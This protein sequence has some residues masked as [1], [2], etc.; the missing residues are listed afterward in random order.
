MRATPANEKVAASLQSLSERISDGIGPPPKLPSI[1]PA[2]PSRDQ[3]PRTIKYLPRDVLGQSYLANGFE[4]QYRAGGKSYRLTTASFESVQE[5]VDAL[6]RYKAFITSTGH[7]ERELKSPGDGG[8]AGSDPFNGPIVAVRS[9]RKLVVTLG[10]PSERSALDLITALLAG[11]S[12]G[13]SP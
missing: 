2:F 10:A 13:E 7:V 4:A 9:G 6:A 1:L 12:S 8:F 3:V 5:A 11:S